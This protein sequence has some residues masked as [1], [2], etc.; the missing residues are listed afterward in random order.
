[1]VFHQIASGRSTEEFSAESTGP[2]PRKSPS[3]WEPTSATPA[4]RNRRVPPPTQTEGR[5]ETESPLQPRRLKRVSSHCEGARP[6][7]GPKSGAES[8]SQRERL[9][10][11]TKLH[12][13]P[14][15][16]PLTS[17]GEL[18]EAPAPLS[19]PRPTEVCCGE[20]EKAELSGG[21]V[22]PTAEYSGP[23]EDSAVAGAGDLADPDLAPAREALGGVSEVEAWPP[24]W[25]ERG[26]E[27][28]RR[29][30]RPTTPMEA[31]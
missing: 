3:Q 4:G 2:P 25:S 23:V 20:A 14:F 19:R 8:P 21:N 15:R 6:S 5:P 16:R 31:R 27:L 17:G 9:V 29:S 7:E 10:S 12:G 11:M 28:S 1:M 30:Q 18:R 22:E 24:G 26:G 13:H